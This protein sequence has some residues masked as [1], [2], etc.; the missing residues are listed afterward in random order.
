M[1][2]SISRL[3]ILLLAL[4]G[5]ALAEPVAHIRI[6]RS[7]VVYA[8]NA[9]QTYTETVTIDRTLLTTRGIQSRDRSA[10]SFYPDQQTLEVME[11]WV[12]QPDGTRLQVG[13]ENRFTRPSA[14]SQDA[15]GF[16]SSMTTTIVYP[17]LRPGSRTHVKFRRVQTTRPMLGFNAWSEA[18]LEDPTLEDR[19]EIDLPADLKLQWR[20]R[21]A[22]TVTDSTEAGTRR[23][24]AEMPPTQ[25]QE[26][27]RST[28][29]TSDF[30]PILRDTASGRK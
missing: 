1:R 17:Q 12:E 27:E 16:T 11:A 5:P 8:V 23:V 4:A 15:P 30:Q 7:D 29:D 22:V 10:I 21:G 9:D 19:M 14:A 3:L 26:P 2:L 24:V 18:E 13:P 20:S 25:G 6:D 28:V